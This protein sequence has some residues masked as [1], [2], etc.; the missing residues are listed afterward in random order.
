MK[1]YYKNGNKVEKPFVK[2]LLGKKFNILSDKTISRLGYEI[3]DTENSKQDEVI[4]NNDVIKF[5]RQ[6]AYKAKADQYLIAYQAYKELGDTKKA[7]EMK[8]LWLKERE[9]I[10]KKYPYIEEVE[11]QKEKQNNN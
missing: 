10:D 5:Q 1:E 3:K 8:E 11:I 6:Q 9:T 4:I 7:L 2:K